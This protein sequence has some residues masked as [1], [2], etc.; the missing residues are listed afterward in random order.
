MIDATT[1]KELNAIADAVL[2]YK[3]RP[4]SKSAKQRKRRA[5]NLAKGRGAAAQGHA[6]EL[7]SSS[8]DDH[9]R[10]LRYR[11]LAHCTRP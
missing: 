9:L 11:L 3:P 7:S 10:T 4:K 6:H 5:A 8:E 1:P 2:A